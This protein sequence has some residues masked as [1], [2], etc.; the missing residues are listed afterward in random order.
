MSLFDITPSPLQKV[1]LKEV[2][3]LASACYLR[4]WN[5]GTAGNFSVRGAKNIAW[6]SPSGVSKGVLQPVSFI[7][8]GI[9]D[10]EVRGGLYVKPSDE[11][12]LHMAVYKRYH[13]AQA[14]IHVHPPHVIRAS[15]AA[16][17]SLRF[18]GHEMAKAL[19]ASG[20][21]E[22]LEIPVVDNT[23][24]MVRLSKDFRSLSLRSSVFVL[25]GH[26]VYAWST[27]PG[28]ALAAIEALEFLCQFD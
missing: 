17:K 7:P 15:I 27:E 10:L 2:C 19:G 21:Q 5:Q 20:H 4:G 18:A 24:D 1:R 13:N 14:I 25:R 11:A 9:E 3:S 23:Q 6:I 28:R 16:A 12:P 22:A 8:L 26:G